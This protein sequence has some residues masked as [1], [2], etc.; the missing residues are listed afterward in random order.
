MSGSR[1]ILLPVTCTF[2]PDLL[3]ALIVGRLG[4]TEAEVTLL[5]VL[6]VPRASPLDENA[7]SEDIER[8]EGELRELAGKLEESGMRTNIRVVLARNL[9][10]GIEG[11]LKGYDVLILPSESFGGLLRKVLSRISIE[12]LAR[13]Y[14]TPIVVVGRELLGC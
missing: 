13:R 11:C 8:I 7:F 6:K 3:K 9:V 2:S 12:R 4:I 14:R 5:K 10:T 1:K